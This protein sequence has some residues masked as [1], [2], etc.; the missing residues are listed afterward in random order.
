MARLFHSGAEIDAGVATT[1]ASAF[2]PDGVGAGAGTLSR[3]TTVF[4]SGAASWKFDSAGT[5]STVVILQSVVSVAGAAYYFRI[6]L[7]AAAAPASAAQIMVID[8][9]NAVR[10]RTDG[11][12]ELM[13]GATAQGSPSSAVT[14][15]TWH[16]VELK[17]TMTSTN[18]TASELTV[19]GVSVATWSGSAAASTGTFF[20]SWGWQD[21]PGASTVINIDDV[22]VNDS[23]GASQNGYPGAGAVVLLKPTADSAVG[24]G[25]TLGTGTAISGNSG[26]TAV[27]NTPP[28]GVAD[29]AVGSDVKQIRN[30]TANASVNYDATMTTYTAAGVGASD[31]V[32]AVM[33]WVATAAPVTTSAKAGTVGVV[34]N[35]TITNVSLSSTGT[36]GAFWAGQAGGSY[37]AGW[38]WSAGTVAAAPTVT[39]GTAPVMRITQVTSSTRIAMVS[40]MFMYVDYTPAAVAAAPIPDVGMA[41][42]VT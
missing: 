34:S 15:S 31:T 1:I 19:D 41:L 12:L 33:P 7:R 23:S 5:N 14:G 37:G 8:S 4:R 11:A 29:V 2:G 26:K 30:A 36:A 16:R 3:D 28:L 18:W 17:A 39:L 25:W 35:P 20:M 24:T 10:L 6:Y 21:A 9:Q 27:S 40:G 22:A 13:R 32:N 38:K 42:T